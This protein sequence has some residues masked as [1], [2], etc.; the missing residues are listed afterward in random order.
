MKYCKGLLFVFLF[1]VLYGC[2]KSAPAYPY[3]EL[4]INDFDSLRNENYLINPRAVQW[5][6]DSIR[7]ASRDTAFVDFYVNGYYAKQ[8]PY[9]W[10]DMFGAD[11]RVDTL[12][13]QLAQ[14]ENEAIKSKTVFVKRITEALQQLRDF[15]FTAKG[16]INR[17]PAVLEYFSTKSLLRYVAGMKFGFINPKKFMNRL[18]KEDPE[19]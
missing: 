17:T 4:S 8:N 1:F 5:Y 11:S 9:I 7:L 16:N 13:K 10:I 19:D 18:E 14:V 6:I 12:A 2:G 3:A 15:D